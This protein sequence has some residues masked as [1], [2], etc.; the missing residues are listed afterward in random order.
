MSG[1][2]PYSASAANKYNC[3]LGLIRKIVSKVWLHLSV[4]DT[5]IKLCTVISLSLPSLSG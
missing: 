5:M 3:H 2:R 4:Y 1:L